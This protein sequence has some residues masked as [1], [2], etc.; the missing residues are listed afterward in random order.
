MG[1]GWG[2]VKLQLSRFHGKLPPTLTLPRKR[3]GDFLDF[4][5]SLKLASFHPETPDEKLAI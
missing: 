5:K 1:G 4:C 2:W 3:G